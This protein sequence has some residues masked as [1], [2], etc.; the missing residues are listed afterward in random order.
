MR[1]LTRIILK[2]MSPLHLGMGRDAYD[3]ASNRLPSDS[4]SAALA[5][6]RAMQGKHEDIEMFLQS[7]SIS[8]A[9]PY[10]GSEF[11]LPSPC[12]RLPIKVKGL[13]EKEYRKDLKKIKYISSSLWHT[14]MKGDAIEI[15][16]AQLHGEFLIEKPADEYKKPMTHV[17][18]QRV[19]VPRADDKDAIPFTFEW[20]FFLHG[21]IESGLYCIVDC[22]DSIRAELIDLFKSLGSIGIGSDRTVGGGLFDVEADEIELPEISGN[23][24]MLLST[25]IPQESEMKHLNLTFSNYSLLKRGGF[26]AGSSNEK[27]RQLRRK[28][29]YMFDTGS[30]FA[31]TLPV[32]GK[33]VNLAPEWNAEG[34]H[35]VYRCGRPLCVTVKMHQDEK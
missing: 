6:V 31:T 15:E 21:E 9:F 7:F 5:S 33:I 12:G 20:T 27:T 8:S 30:V 19:M 24:T 26:M 25:Y 10:C 11:F 34:M 18:N 17:I 13:E 4:L 29:V 22:E 23:A 16:P 2:N 1:K 35:P 28:T 3:T 32:E 14:M